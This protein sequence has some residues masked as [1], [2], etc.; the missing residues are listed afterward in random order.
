MLYV[1]CLYLYKVYIYIPIFVKGIYLVY[2]FISSIF[3]MSNLN[4]RLLGSIL[5]LK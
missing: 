1:E 5:N 4:D 3:Y 2:S